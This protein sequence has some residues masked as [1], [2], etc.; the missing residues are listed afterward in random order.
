M[1]DSFTNVYNDQARAAAYSALEFPATY[2][3]AF[4]DIPSMIREHVTG[5]RAVDFGCG[6]GRSTRFLRDLGFDVIGIDISAAMVEL[7]RR[8]DPKGDYRLVEDG[9][10]GDLPPESFDLIL[11]AFAFDNI[12]VLQNKVRLFKALRRL[13]KP[14][15]RMI[16]LVSS[17]AIYVHEWA[18]FTTKDF[19]KNREARSGDLVHIVMLDVEDQRPV[20]DIYC[21]NEDYQTVWREA[22]LKPVSIH[23]PLGTSDEPYQWVSETKVSP[24]VISVLAPES[25]YDGCNDAKGLR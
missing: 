15:G 2:Y 14:G 16:N 22:G 24:W 23:R 11:S 9:T 6:A 19:P 17:P 13:L 21:T 7:A 3:L 8:S 4:R 25:N 10:T 12:P 1:S 18:S 5:K 20:E